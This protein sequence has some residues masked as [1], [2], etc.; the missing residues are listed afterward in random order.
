MYESDATDPVYAYSFEIEEASATKV[1]EI[2][3]TFANPVEAE[4]VTFTITKAEAG[5]PTEKVEWNDDEDVAV[6]TTS[7]KMTEGT[8]TVTATDAETEDTDSYDF[9][10]RKQYVDEIVI[11]NDTALTD[12]TDKKI[13]Y[14]YYDVFDQYG[15][16]IRSSTS[17]QWT[18]SAQTTT[19]NK[20]NGQIKFTNAQEWI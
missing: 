10:V 9:E 7:A 13:A 6:I 2:T 3:V 5:V 4:N 19:A 8:Y 15:E 11:L 1:N 16:S 17:I 20:T 12:R 18:S 14:A